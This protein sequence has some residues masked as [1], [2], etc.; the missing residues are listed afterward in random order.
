MSIFKIKTGLIGA[1]MFSLLA[2]PFQLAAEEKPKNFKDW[3]YKC[4]TPK[5][6][7][8][9]ICFV[10]QRVTNKDNNQKIAD[11]TVAYAP[12]GNKPIMV[13]TLPLGVFL[14]A[15]IQLKVDDGEEAARATFVQCIQ[16]GCQARVSLDDKLTTKMKGGNRLRVAFFT[17]QQKQLAFPISLNG[18]TAALSSLKK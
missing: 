5:G 7:N 4:E 18:F 2:V 3:G 17:P 15:G 12:K 11:V 10:F 14:P 1:I 6:F 16:D 8:K 9:E 13:I